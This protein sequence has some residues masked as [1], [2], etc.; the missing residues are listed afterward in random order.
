MPGIKRRLDSG[1]D[2]SGFASQ[3]KRVSQEHGCG[4]DRSERV[5]DALTSDVR[6][7]PMHRFVDS[8]GA[9]DACGGQHAES[10]DR[11]SGLIRE[12]VAEHVLGEE[13]V[14]VGGAQ[15]E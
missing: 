12:D 2:A 13:D 6:C 5:G 4:E 1:L 11:T 14:D 10:A 9:S 8:D 15:H 7:G 3:P